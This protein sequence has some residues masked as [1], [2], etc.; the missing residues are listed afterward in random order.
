MIYWWGNVS[1]KKN[2][3]KDRFIREDQGR[4]WLYNEI[5]KCKILVN[6]SLYI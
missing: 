5:Y 1:N 3:K 4:D 2:K 6:P